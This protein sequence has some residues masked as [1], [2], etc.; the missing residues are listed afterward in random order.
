MV[1]GLMYGV[2]DSEEVLAIYACRNI[3]VAMGF[4]RMVLERCLNKQL[5]IVD[6]GPWYPYTLNIPIRGLVEEILLRGS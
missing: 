4:A 1:L 2:F 6:R 3:M 5:I